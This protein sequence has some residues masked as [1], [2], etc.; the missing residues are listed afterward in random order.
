G[1]L[2]IVGWAGATALPLALALVLRRSDAWPNVAATLWVVALVISPIAGSDILRYI[3]WSAGATALALWGVGDS[4]SE[5][6]NAGAAIFAEP[7]L[8]SYSSHVMDKWERSASLAGLGVLFLVG[9]WALE[10]PRRR[11]VAQARGGYAS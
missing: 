7:F 9:G 4:S 3:W 1:S 6:V 2:A 5:R 8:T 10:R 11:L